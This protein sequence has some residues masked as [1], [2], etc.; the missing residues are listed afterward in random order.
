MVVPLFVRKR[1]RAYKRA[2]GNWLVAAAAAVAGWLWVIRCVRATAITH[3]VLN[4]IYII[5]FNMGN[6]SFKMN[7]S[8]K[9]SFERF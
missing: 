3:K 8:V 6:K 1:T 5:Y 7:S 9:E 2:I 4:K